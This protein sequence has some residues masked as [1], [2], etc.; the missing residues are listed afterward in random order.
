[1][2]QMSYFKNIRAVIFDMDGLLLDSES[3]AMS[4]FLE[5]CREHGLEPDIK[6]Y[7]KCVGTN[8]A[9]TREI[10]T[11]GYGPDFPFDAVFTLWNKKYWDAALNRPIPVKAG[12]LDLL[13]YLG[14]EEIRKAVVTSTRREKAIRMLSNANLLDYFE[15]VLCGDEINKGKPDPEMYLTGCNK[16]HV[17]PLN[18]LALEDS[19]NGVLSAFNAGMTVIQVPDMVTPG[20][21][22]KVLGH[23]VVG[24]L[25]KV[26]ELLRAGSLELRFKR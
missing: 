12:A 3:V 14:N 25:S 10:L 1:M 2:M 22:V 20:E 11:K 26:E 21:R 8:E 17:Q 9:G 7:F 15:F 24:S 6:V 5:S 18:C 16:L 4:T 23:R 19:D 13:Q